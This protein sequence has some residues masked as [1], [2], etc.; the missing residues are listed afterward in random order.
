MLGER[1]QLYIYT[2]TNQHLYINHQ[3]SSNTDDD[4]LQKSALMEWTSVAFVCVS[5]YKSFGF[6]FVIKFNV[7]TYLLN[8]S[9]NLLI[10]IYLLEQVYQY[11]MLMIRPTL[12]NFVLHQ[13]IM[14]KS[15]SAFQLSIIGIKNT[16]MEVCSDINQL[17]N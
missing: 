13:K 14:E 12:T 5:Q 4:R 3:L 16:F 1:Q 17:H 2:N 6:R 9:F 11:E 10:L 8:N 15:G 7:S